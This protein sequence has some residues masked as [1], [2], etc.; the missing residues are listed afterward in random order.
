MFAACA[1]VMGFDFDPVLLMRKIVLPQRFAGIAVVI[2][3]LCAFLI[4]RPVCPVVIVSNSSKRLVG[5]S[6][7]E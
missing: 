1:L 7:L 2:D 6:G 5:G 4:R 3:F